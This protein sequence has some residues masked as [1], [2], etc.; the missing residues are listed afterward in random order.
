[1]APAKPKVPTGRSP[2]RPRKHV[3]GSSKVIDSKVSKPV[4]AA[5]NPN[6]LR[7]GK[8]YA[9]QDILKRV[10]NTDKGRSVLQG[11]SAKRGRGRPKKAIDVEMTDDGNTADAK[12]EAEQ[13][14]KG[15]DVIAENVDSEAPTV[16]S[17]FRTTEAKRGRGRPK[18]ISEVS[19]GNGD[20]SIVAT[21]DGSAKAD[22]AEDDS[23]QEKINGGLLTAGV[24]RGPGRPSKNQNPADD[25]APSS[26]TLVNATVK[27]GRG[28]PPKKKRSYFGRPVPVIPMGES[29]HDHEQEL[30]GADDGHVI[31]LDTGSEASKLTSVEDTVKNSSNAIDETDGDQVPKLLPSLM[32]HS[33]GRSPAPPRTFSSEQD[34]KSNYAIV[35]THGRP[36]RHGVFNGKAD[37]EGYGYELATL[38]DEKASAI[39]DNGTC[40]DDSAHA[41]SSIADASPEGTCTVE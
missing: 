29:V 33:A 40:T 21:A 18:V 24:K 14:N 28:R 5:N 13:V 17:G 8:V 10:S 19:S 36:R 15:E 30:D 35:E 20:D 37:A 2:D 9:Q 16:G 32:P 39:E 25:L 27:R 7:S 31:L 6:A 38:D 41:D 4:Q 1:M 11:T 12:G 23:A 3:L 26:L 34:L 22:D